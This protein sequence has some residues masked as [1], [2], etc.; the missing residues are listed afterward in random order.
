MGW[1]QGHEVQTLSPDNGASSD[2]S[3]RVVAPV[4]MPLTSAPLIGPSAVPEELRSTSEPRPSFGSPG[5]TAS[6]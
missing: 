2:G 5:W 6:K 1:M 4:R 3:H